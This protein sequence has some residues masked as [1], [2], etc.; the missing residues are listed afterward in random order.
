MLAEAGM[1]KPVD[2]V[3]TARVS[4]RTEN[5]EV[6][7]IDILH[8]VI[9]FILRPFG[10]TPELGTLNTAGTFSNQEQV[11]EACRLGAL[12][13]VTWVLVETNTCVPD[14]LL[15][16]QE[17]NVMSA[18]ERTCLRIRDAGL[19]QGWRAGNVFELN[20]YH[21]FEHMEGDNS[22]HVLYTLCFTGFQCCHLRPR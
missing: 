17:R 12:A 20:L 2:T 3:A 19:L 10:S 8:D 9:V 13:S 21:R 6:G 11:Y 7:T 4:A 5:R 1:D 18:K 16:S 15:T 22:P 14:T